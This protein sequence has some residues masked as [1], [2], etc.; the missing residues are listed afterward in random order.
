MSTETDLAWLA[1][2]IDGE[3]TVRLRPKK[4]RT[5]KTEYQPYIAVAMTHFDTITRCW[6]LAGKRGSI[7]EPKQAPP[8]KRQLRWTIVSRGALEVAKA[9]VPYMVTKK[10]EM[11]AIIDHYEN[12][13]EA[14]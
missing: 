6:E 11:Q 3:G 13:A 2:I 5:G 12:I 10:S 14:V 4:G 7:C 8:R 1:G 9:C